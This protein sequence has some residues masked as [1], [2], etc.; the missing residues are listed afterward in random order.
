MIYNSSTGN[1]SNPCWRWLTYL[2]RRTLGS[3]PNTY[4]RTPAPSPAEIPLSVQGCCQ[5]IVAGAGAGSSAL[6]EKLILLGSG[7][8]K[9]MIACRKFQG[10]ANGA[11]PA[12]NES[13]SQD[14][15]HMG[16]TRYAVYRN[17]SSIFYL[18][19]ARVKLDVRTWDPSVQRD[20][21][22]LTQVTKQ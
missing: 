13:A 10:S 14:F 21:F 5:T 8:V 11:G 3:T 15:R 16:Q 7:I 19:R 20:P 18:F 6:V 12:W 1:I 22:K 4:P 9:D 2:L 17:D